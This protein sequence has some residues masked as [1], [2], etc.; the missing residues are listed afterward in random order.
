[1]RTILTYKLDICMLKVIGKLLKNKAKNPK[2]IPDF[3]KQLEPSAYKLELKCQPLCL[4]FL[5]SFS[6]IIKDNPHEIILK[7][8]KVSD[9]Y[10]KL[11]YK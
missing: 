11:H 6:P 1:M 4:K 3:D 8:C 2:N 5:Q 7:H 10:K 9:R